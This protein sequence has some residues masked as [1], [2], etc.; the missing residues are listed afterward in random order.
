MY[1]TNV[2]S[3]H[4]LK[5]GY[6]LINYGYFVNT[7]V[8]NLWMYIHI[9]WCVHTLICNNIYHISYLVNLDFK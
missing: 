1:I 2:L 4:H 5:Y 7:D 8:Y 9:K 3:I 6:R